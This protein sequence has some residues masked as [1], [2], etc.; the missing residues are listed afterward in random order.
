MVAAAEL[1]EAI[2]PTVLILEDDPDLG[3]LYCEVLADAG[4]NVDVVPNG[5]EGLAYLSQSIPDLVVSDIMM[6]VMDGLAFLREVRDQ[7]DLRFLPVILLTTRSNIDDVVAGFAIGADDY[8]AKP[9]DPRELVMRVKA[10]IERPPVPVETLD[11]DRKSGLLS[12][13]GFMTAVEVEMERARR[14]NYHCC[15]AVIDIYEHARLLT[16]FGH[17]AEAGIANTFGRMLLDWARPL[18]IAARLDDG[19]FAVFMPECTPDTA[20]D[21]L[22]ALTRQVVHARLQ[23]GKEDISITPISGYSE[24]DTDL[25]FRTSMDQARIAA[26][27]AESH[28]DLRP[29]PFDPLMVTPP[30]AGS[31]LSRLS[32]Y[33]DRF[34]LPFQML[35][36]YVI[37]F[38]LPFGIYVAVGELGFDITA[39]VYY[40]AVFAMLVTCVLIWAEGFLSLK[41]ADLPEVREEDFGPVTAII[42]AY[43]PNEAPTLES[44]IEAFLRMDYPAEMKVILAYNTPVDMPIETRLREIARADPRFVP[45]RVP[46]SSSKA[47]NVNA[48]LSLVTSPVVGV[49]DA[50]HQPD[51]D[52]FRRA[53]RWMA[54]GADVVQGHCLIRNGEVSWVARTVAIEFE[55]IYAVNHYGRMKLHDFGLFGGSNGFWRTELIREL[56]MRGSMLTEDIDSSIR[57]VQAGKT[58]IS[59]PELIS[60]ELAPT[61]LKGLTNQRL[62]WAQGW[63]QV[64]TRQVMPSLK[65]KGLSLRQKIGMV[66]LLG[67]R[68]AFPWMSMQIVPIVAYDW[69]R[70]GEVDMSTWTQGILFW[71]TLFILLTGPGQM[72][73]TWFRADKT[74]RAHRGW[75]WGY[76]IRSVL[77][78]AGYK[79]LLARVANLKEAAG[80][81]AWKVTPR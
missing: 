2:R 16:Y 80:E 46:S 41:R 59:D 25:P 72:L 44:T 23:V 13:A 18:D 76:L 57:A 38:L 79:N 81:R 51:A 62:R 50:D 21:R 56:R 54:A 1:A 48:A 43:L 77:F 47:Q 75:F 65:S 7:Q 19:S 34:R 17:R 36:T 49:Y 64:T 9:V 26:T 31:F 40:A 71:I 58:I 37:G 4:Y 61:T 45:F 32:K 63:Y 35:L 68:E 52:S 55:Q 24:A 12:Q 20:G 30:Q 22:E 11:T 29:M 6:P 67:W 8:V 39:P 53:W 60:R 33:T 74:F 73:F 10:K 70:K 14:G 3:E 42:A 28:L 69:W 78:Y 66:H 15:V 27:A 5:R